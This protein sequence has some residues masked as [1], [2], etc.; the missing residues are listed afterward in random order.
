M[1]FCTDFGAQAPVRTFT[2][3]T[4]W[5]PGI[6]LNN[7]SLFYRDNDASTV[8]PSVD[9]VPYT[10][11]MVDEQEAY[12]PELFGQDF[13]VGAITGTGNPADDGVGYGTVIHLKKAFKGNTS[14]LIQITPPLS[15]Q[16]FRAVIHTAG[17]AAPLP[18]RRQSGSNYGSSRSTGLDHQPDGPALS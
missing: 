5:Y 18:D 17:R 4:G 7:D 15:G 13:G 9:N 11:R 10:V 12:V 1:E 6:E 14:A 16:S 2:D 3:D 8:V